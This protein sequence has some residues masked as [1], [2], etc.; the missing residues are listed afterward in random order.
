MILDKQTAVNMATVTANKYGIRMK[1]YTDFDDN[2][3]EEGFSY[4]P[5]AFSGYELFQPG[6]EVVLQIEPKP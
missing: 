5:C 1:V 6:C 4:A 2:T 3:G